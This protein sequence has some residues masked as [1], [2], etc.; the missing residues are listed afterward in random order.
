[1]GNLVK[2]PEE[3]LPKRDPLER[4]DYLEADVQALR[5]VNEGRATS[6]QQ[7]RA[8]RFLIN[9]ICGNYDMPYRPDSSRD[10]DFA[11]GKMWVGQTVVY[12]LKIAPTVTISDE[13]SV[14]H[15]MEGEQPR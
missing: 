10:T 9:E 4:P 3:K 1:M 8:M 15:A 14:R 2:E 5:A 12:F 6:D 7:R 13:I 11:L